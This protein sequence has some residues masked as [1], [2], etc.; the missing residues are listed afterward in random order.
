MSTG[1]CQQDSTIR[2]ANNLLI[3]LEQRRA[4]DSLNSD[5]NLR[6]KLALKNYDSVFVYKDRVINNLQQTIE[7]MKPEWY[8]NKYLWYGLGLLTA[9]ILIK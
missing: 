8:D 7:A 5:I 9:Y 6:L 1:Y 2:K 4:V 3:E